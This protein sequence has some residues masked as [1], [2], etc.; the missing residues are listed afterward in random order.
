MRGGLLF[1]TRRLLGTA[2]AGV[3]STFFGLTLTLL[4][5]AAAGL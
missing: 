3:F 5:A 1:Q 2:V 4:L